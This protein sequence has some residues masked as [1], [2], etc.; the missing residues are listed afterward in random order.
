MGDQASM[1]NAQVTQLAQDGM[2]GKKQRSWWDFGGRFDDWMNNARENATLGGNKFGGDRYKDQMKELGYQGGG[3]NRRPNYAKYQKAERIKQQKASLDALNSGKGLD[4]KGAGLGTNIGKGYPAVY[5]GR[6][7]IKVKLPP[8]GSYEPEVTVG[9][10]RFFAV[11][12]GD[13]V[14]YVSNFKAGQKNLGVGTK[15][16]QAPKPK[17]APPAS[18]AGGVG[19]APSASGGG[20][21]S[22]TVVAPPV[23]PQS[24][25]SFSAG[26]F[27]GNVPRGKTMAATF[28]DFLYADLIE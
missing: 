16:P 11:K 25:K 12:Q 27:G 2:V 4:L 13:S 28:A 17:P 9:G 14:I 26:G 8:G 3:A 19:P 5:K 10:K 1:P 20:A 15:P 21:A 18:P 24:S 7:A 23:A 6:E 22:T